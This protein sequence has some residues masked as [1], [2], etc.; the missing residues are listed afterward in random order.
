MSYFSMGVGMVNFPSMNPYMTMNPYMNSCS[1]FSPFAGFSPYA[2]MSPAMGWMSP[3]NSQTM[4]LMQTMQM[5][6]MLYTMMLMQLALRQFTQQS[7]YANPGYNQPYYQGRG[8]IPYTA[9]GSVN[10]TPSGDYAGTKDPIL[11]LTKIAGGDVHVSSAKRNK[12]HTLSGGV[13]DHYAGN[14]RAYAHDLSWGSSRP[15]AESDAAASRVVAALG[16]PSNWGSHGGV[17]N[18]T[19]NGI[20]YQVIYKSMVGG[21]HYN[22]IH[23]GARKV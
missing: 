5:M 8:N 18:K 14:T 21:N 19:I 23:V 12:E 11:Q 4:M 9:Q 7:G 3:M 13:S 17:F 22:H 16:G 6:N 1:G 2:G 10:I 15:T 20:R